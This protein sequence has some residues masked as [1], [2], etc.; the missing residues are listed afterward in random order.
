[1]SG[2]SAASTETENH[3][4]LRASPRHPPVVE[5]AGNHLVIGDG[6]QIDSQ[7][8]IGG[9]NNSLLIGGRCQV[10]GF[11]PVGGGTALIDPKP[12]AMANLVVRGSG[13]IIEIA[14][15]CRLGANVT[16]IGDNSHI[17]I[18]PRCAINGFV[19]LLSPTGSTLVIGADT[20]MVQ[21]SIQLHE[22]GQI[23]FGADCMVSSQT[24]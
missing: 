9:D 17:R 7:I 4:D 23:I 21:V 8:V 12:G 10:A 1:M 18:G 19:A 14:E 11:A 20:T 6:G 2:K 15:D 13:N 5:G 3:I 24:Y 16:I 22:P